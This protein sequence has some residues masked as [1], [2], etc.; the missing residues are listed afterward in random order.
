MKEIYI[1]CP[2]CA[3]TWGEDEIITEECNSCGY[4]HY[5]DEYNEPEEQINIEKID[6]PF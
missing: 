1:E 6:L 2:H 3:A 5:P 4:P